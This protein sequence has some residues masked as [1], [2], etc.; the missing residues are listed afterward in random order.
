ML[1]VSRVPIGQTLLQREKIM[2]KSFKYT[3]CILIILLTTGS[4]WAKDKYIVTV[5]PFTLHSSENIEYVKQGIEDMLITR[6]SVP[7]KIDVTGKDVVQEELKKS[8][9]KEISPAD[10]YNIGKKLKS[11]YVVWGSITKIGSSIS[12][13]GKLVDIGA[14]KSDVGFYTQSQNLDEVIPKINDFSQKIVQH[15]L[16]AT[17]QVDATAP[18][19]AVPPPT[20]QNS[21]EAQIIAGMKSGKKGTLTSVINPEYIN[22]P[23]PFNR[24]GFWMSQNFPTEFKGM[25]IGDVNGDGL[26]E[27]VTIDAHN[28]YIYQKVGNELKLLE[29]IAGKLYDTYLAV[30]VADINKNGIK[31]IIVTSLNGS[32]LD[33]FVLEYKNGKYIQIASGLTW[34][35]RVIDTPSGIPLLMGQALGIGDNF[36]FKTPI[37][38]IIYSDGKYIS[39][40]KMKTPLGLSVYGLNFENLGAGSNEK[41]IVL[42]E[43]DYL[44]IFEKTNKPLSRIFTFG[45]KNEELI[46]RSDDVYGG[47]NNYIDDDNKNRS[48]EVDAKSAFINLRILTHDTNK[49]GKKEIIIVKNLSS[50]GRILKNLKLFTSSEIYN[51]EWDGMGMAENWR[52]KKINGYVADYVLKDIDNDGK[53]EIVLALVLSVGTSIKDKSV[54]VVYKLDAAQ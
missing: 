53:P 6:I 48:S 21:R 4:L 26:N 24:R 41:I 2:R 36:A 44:C 32:T 8:S 39:H 54:I 52:T 45:F 27:I 16:G 37:Y 42:D 20:P 9:V 40:E 3:F 47:S 49:D 35:L 29:K 28:V 25:D 30:D 11:D 38:E 34:F 17:P 46:W 19:A 51:L 12:V 33:S 43:L 14:A 13:D 31:E 18:A 5:L 10:V 22:S 1:E 23:D 50:V 7:N 15:I